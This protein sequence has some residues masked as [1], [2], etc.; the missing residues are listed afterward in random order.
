MV[1]NKIDKE[2]GRLIS[3]KE[4]EDLAKEL[5]LPFIETSAKSG[6]NISETFEDLSERFPVSDNKSITGGRRYCQC[7]VR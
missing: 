7:D 2:D 6:I 3:T 1:A 4:G 5:G